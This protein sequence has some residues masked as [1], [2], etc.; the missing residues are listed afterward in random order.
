LR[1]DSR[2]RVRDSRAAKAVYKPGLFTLNRVLGVAVAATL[3]ACVVVVALLF[4]RAARVPLVKDAVGGSAIAP[5]LV[6][7]VEP[8]VDVLDETLGLDLCGGRLER[9][10]ADACAPPE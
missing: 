1:G 7:A 3:A 5:R 2:R 4:V 6:D 9:I 10:I 8:A